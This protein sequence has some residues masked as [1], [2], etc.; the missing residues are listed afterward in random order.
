MELLILLIPIVIMVWKTWSELTKDQPKPVSEEERKAYERQ[1][2]IHER[3]SERSKRAKWNEIENTIRADASALAL[4]RRQLVYT[5]AYGENTEA[6][7]REIG[8]YIK[9]RGLD[10]K[11][12][13]Y[14]Y[15]DRGAALSRIEV[16]IEDVAKS[17]APSS[18]LSSTVTDPC[19]FERLCAETLQRVGWS[20]QLTARTG[21]QGIDVIACKNGIKC[22]IQCKLYSK[23]VGNG[24]VQEVAAGRSFE[25]AD[26]AVVVS[27]AGYTKSARVLAQ[28]TN[29]LLLDFSELPELEAKL[30]GTLIMPALPPVSIPSRTQQPTLRNLKKQKPPLQKIDRPVSRIDGNDVVFHCDYCGQRLVVDKKGLGAEI[31]C[32]TCAETIRVR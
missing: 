2:E 3:D 26:H 14:D 19:E 30:G 12:R 11:A 9:R 7:V 28:N 5:D 31:D 18:S 10:E 1:R 24:A 32:P 4:K 16:L 22:V 29:V 8:Y 21:D 25:R 27:K 17:N 20:T 23:P 15:F 6:W 13:L